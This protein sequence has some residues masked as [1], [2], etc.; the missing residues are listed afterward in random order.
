MN[1]TDAIRS[2]IFCFWLEM[3]MVTTGSELA[4]DQ[5]IFWPLQEL[6]LSGTA[7]IDVISISSS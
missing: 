7:I 1:V 5:I 4:N 6:V 2:S 3:H